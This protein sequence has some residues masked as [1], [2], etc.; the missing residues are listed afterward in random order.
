M[1][2][3]KENPVVRK[4]AILKYRRKRTLVKKMLELAKLRDL[5]I[6]VII[7]DPCH[8][9]IEELY[10]EESAKLSSMNLMM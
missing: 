10:S 4:K 5:K 2:Q 7:Y 6:N 9:K 1:P 8:H 3:R